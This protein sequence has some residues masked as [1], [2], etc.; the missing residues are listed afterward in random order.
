M[1]VDQEREEPAK[2]RKEAGKMQTASAAARERKLELFAKRIST[3]LH[4]HAIPAKKD[5]LLHDGLSEFERQLILGCREDGMS[6][7][8]IREWLKEI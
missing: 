1:D 7:S 3:R 8:E 2:E 5:E 6:D 4:P